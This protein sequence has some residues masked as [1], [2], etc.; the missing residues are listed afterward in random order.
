MTF[1]LDYR[2]AYLVGNLLLF[3]VWLVIFILRKDLRREQITVGLIL[4]IVAPLTD[5]LFFYNDYWRPEYLLNF[6]IDGVRLGFESSFFGFII[7]GISTGIY[8]FVLSR[9]AVFS[10]PRNLLAFLVALA[11]ILGTY[12]LIKLGLN[13]IWASIMSL[14][15]CSIYMALKDRDLIKDMLLSSLFLTG[16]IIIFYTIWF[17][18]YPDALQKLWVI[19]NLS[20][21]K[22]WRTPF[23]EIMWFLSAG[24]FVG[25]FYE[26]WKNVRKYK[27]I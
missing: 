9:K 14:I 2:Y 27:K 22:L 5:Y 10:K 16:I 11:N 19:N 21:I 18:I 12:L 15:I 4:V 17:L 23:E 20:G 25:T 7:G 24:L 8:E 1:L 13:S 26:F 6:N 3:L